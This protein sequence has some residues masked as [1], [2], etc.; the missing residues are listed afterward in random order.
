MNC[1]MKFLRIEAVVFIILNGAE[2]D[3]RSH[4]EGSGEETNGVRVEGVDGWKNE[5]R[6]EQW[7]EVE[8]LPLGRNEESYEGKHEQRDEEM[9]GESE[10][11]MYKE[12]DERNNGNEPK[13]KEKV[14]GWTTLMYEERDEG[15]NDTWAYISDTER[16]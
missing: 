13:N 2:V 12:R 5:V 11:K 6:D 4:Y 10:R 16:K 9:T 7:N 8:N 3:G 1:A 14:E 15:T